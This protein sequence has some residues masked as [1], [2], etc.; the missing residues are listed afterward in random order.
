MEGFHLLC[1]DHVFGEVV[2]AIRDLLHLGLKDTASLAEKNAHAA[3][4]IGVHL[5]AQKPFFFHPI[6]QGGHGGW[7]AADGEGQFGG[8]DAII[9]VQGTQGVPLQ[10]AQ[11]QGN[12][13][14]FINLFQ[15]TISLF[16]IGCHATVK[17]ESYWIVHVVIVLQEKL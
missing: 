2:E 8:R 16:N 1:C 3:A 5:A 9:R 14:A 13:Q 11:A 7:V 6:Q 17:A 12:D 10:Q 15:V 4:I